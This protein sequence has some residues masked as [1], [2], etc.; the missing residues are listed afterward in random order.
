MTSSDVSTTVSDDFVP[1]D[2]E[3]GVEFL[4]HQLKEKNWLERGGM[5]AVSDKQ[6]GEIFYMRTAKMKPLEQGREGL[7]ATFQQAIADYAARATSQFTAE[8]RD[9]KNGTQLGKGT[10]SSS[11]T[12]EKEAAAITL[13][14]AIATSSSSLYDLELSH[15]SDLPTHI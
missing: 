5:I 8:L 3:G 9:T 13:A 12:T 14:A 10:H 15:S 1:M 2:E 7:T 4:R 6:S 11:S